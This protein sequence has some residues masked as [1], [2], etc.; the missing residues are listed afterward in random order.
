MQLHA[1]M[2]TSGCANTIVSTSVVA[3]A[4]RLFDDLQWQID[5]KLWWAITTL[6]ILEWKEPS[7]RTLNKPWG[8][9]IRILRL[10]HVSIELAVD[11]RT[12]ILTYCREGTGER[13]LLNGGQVNGAMTVAGCV[14][15]CKAAGFS[16]AGVEY[17]GECCEYSK[18]QPRRN[19]TDSTFIDC[20]NTIHNA[21]TA[22]PGG[23][24]DCNMVC[25][26]NSSEYCG[27]GGRLDIYKLGYAGSSSTS[28]SK[29]AATSSTKVS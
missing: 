24:S 13:A 4:R 16:L 3:P 5:R 15:A 22:A 10:L 29:A 25:K 7:S 26:G 28:T 17:A 8:E 2:N 11:N 9:R 14:Q 20:D 19:I 27:A 12:P 21:A 18:Q 1:N 6:S 23:L